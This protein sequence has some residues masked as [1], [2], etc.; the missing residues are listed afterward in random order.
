VPA[1]RMIVGFGEGG[2]VYLRV[3][4]TNTLERSNYR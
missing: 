4:A 3:G 1:D 2:I